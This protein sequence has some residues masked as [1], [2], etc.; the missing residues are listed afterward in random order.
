MKIG[1]VE[2]NAA[3][4]SIKDFTDQKEV[5]DA[6]DELMTTFTSPDSKKL[7]DK[8]IV[9]DTLDE[10]NNQ[11]VNLVQEGGGVLGIALVG[12]TFI[13]EEVGIRFMRLAGTSAGAI[14]TSIMAAI[15]EKET[16]KSRKVLGYLCG[17]NLFE[18]VD[19]HPFTKRVIGNFITNKGF[20][21]KIRNGLKGTAIL[22]AGL[23]ALDVVS[24]GLQAHIPAFSV[25]GRISFVLTGIT[26]L[27]CFI[28]F[29]YIRRLIQRF[30]GCGFGINPGNNFHNWI[31]EILED[32]N[33][34]TVADL[35]NKATRLPK[36]LKLRDGKQGKDAL[37]NLNPDVTLITS[38]IITE[39]KIE[40]PKMWD[41]F[42]DDMRDKA[43][44][45]ADF[46][47]ASMSIP[48]FFESHIISN[49]PKHNPRVAEK[50]KTHLSIEPANI[51][52]AVRFVDGGILS[53]FPINVFYNPEVRTP[54]LPTFGIDLDDAAEQTK[55]TTAFSFG[56]YLGKLFNTVRYY[57]DKDFLLKN[58]LYRK[59]IGT[60]KVSDF[61]W[62][63]FGLSD[64]EKMQLFAR[65][66]QAAKDFLINFK[67][68]EYKAEREKVYDELTKAQIAR[69]APVNAPL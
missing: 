55:A 24:L 22:L 26:L 15:E 16:K 4:L 36:G 3:S 11:Y 12:Y 60:I 50:W 42:T 43:L 49:I 9:S 66:A 69:A 68:A 10:N 52:D 39:N 32:N 17:K 45:P 59:G 33:V 28:G 35:Q 37:K 31:K 2:Q 34:F 44:H 1:K 62:L 48:I 25:V 64:A 57:Y 29:S 56:A 13:L 7:Y 41:L 58:H 53:N 5:H 67:W 19:G 51:P 54:R 61:N 20:F 18:F 8:L 23:L 46:V 65:G 40:F 14:N 30:K 38:D 27:A 21:K 63:N 47:R 6:L